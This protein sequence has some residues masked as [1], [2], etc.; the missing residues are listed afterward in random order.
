MKMTLTKKGIILV[1][2]PLLF[3]LVFVGILAL[4]NAQ[5]E[6]EAVDAFRSGRISNGT[7]QLIRD[8]FE[9]V[10]I[11]RAELS[12]SLSSE[13]YESILSRIRSDLNELKD[14]VK[15]NPQEESIVQTSANAGE[16]AYSIIKNLR[17]SFETD[18]PF[19]A[20]NH[21]NM[22]RD[23]MRSCLKR[24]VPQ[25][26][27]ELAQVEKEKEEKSHKLQAVFRQQIKYLL[28]VGVIFNII[29]AIVVSLLFSKKIVG[30]LKI[31]VD[32][33]YRLASNL[34]LNAPVAGSDEIAN[35]DQTFHAMA[36][37]L[38][39]AKKKERDLIDNS[40]EV[41]CSLDSSWRVTAINPACETVFGLTEYDLLGTSIVQLIYKDDVSNAL[42]SLKSAQGG[43]PECS[44][45]TRIRRKD[46]KVIDVLWSVRWV[47]TEDSLFCVVHDITERKEAERMKQEVMAMVTHDL[48]TPLATIK[49]FHEMV[50]T[51]MFG[52][53]SKRG[54]E[55]LQT[56]ES[57]TD[58]MLTL[59]KDLLEIEKIKSG[60]LEITPT[61]LELSKLFEQST[62]S[63][64]DWA[65][66][67]NVDFKVIAT[68][69]TI[70]AGGDRI[71]QVLANLLSNAVKFSPPQSSIT[72][73]AIAE[74]EQIKIMIA[75]HGRGI[76][77]ALK[78]AIFDRFQ[79]V[80]SAD[81]REKGGSGLGLAICKAIIEAHGGHIW[82]ENN[83]NGGSVFCFTV[84]ANAT[85]SYNKHIQP[86]STT[87]VSL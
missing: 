84:S 56:A 74:T 4:L 31:L 2:I 30:R 59:I 14:A 54:L 33:S 51:G 3:E 35:L 19:A 26:L 9:T 18:S 72:L 66:K 39:E 55:L 53:L 49:S 11:T 12:R 71:N 61:R 70:F 10:S 24:M 50:A 5:A 16:E 7:N 40:V 78:E 62:N 75:D 38:Q 43:T 47:T 57:N 21:L 13:N 60:R 77:D 23:Q 27:I 22:M 52:E 79:Q 46:G 65:A 44:F 73:S 41:I 8:M 34:P 69:L 64:A 81:D 67:R 1:S 85:M 17:L 80:E 6:Q 63:L 42:Q 20:A 58:R 25:E 37:A 15:G 36:I 68:D 29:L 83:D 82:V 28:I 45:E 32:N 48:R 76:P 87:Q 86:N